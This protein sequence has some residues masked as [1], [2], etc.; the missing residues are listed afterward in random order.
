MVDGDIAARPNHTIL[1]KGKAYWDMRGL[2]QLIRDDG[3]VDMS[4]LSTSVTT[5]RVQIFNSTSTFNAYY[6][7][8]DKETAEAHSE[9]T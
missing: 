2:Q 9:A 4:T 5:S 7:T 6:W 3:S 8:P 1:H